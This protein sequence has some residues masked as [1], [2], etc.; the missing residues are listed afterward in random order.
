MKHVV[1]AGLLIA[2]LAG[3]V[4][5]ILAQ[6]NSAPAGG[7]VIGSVTLTKK[8]LA[9]GQPLAPG[10]YQVRLSG[11]QPR[12][13]VGQSP[14][15]ERYVEFLRAGKVAGREMATVISNVDLST[16]GPSGKRPTN[17]SRVDTLRGE[18]YLRVWINRSGTNYLIHLPP[19]A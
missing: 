18:D 10:T 14:D 8:V 15:S 16:M 2:T 17:G 19:A 11:D 6:G 12:P 9:D 7:T 13:V 4:M 3:P 5:P 1:R